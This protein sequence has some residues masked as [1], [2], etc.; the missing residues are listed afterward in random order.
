ML[1][2]NASAYDAS[3]PS[4]EHGIVRSDLQR[5]LLL[6]PAHLS[7]VAWLYHV[8]GFDQSEVAACMGVSRRTVCNYLADFA[9]RARSLDARGDGT[10]RP[11]LRDVANGR[12][13]TRAGPRLID[14]LASRPLVWL[15]GD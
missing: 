11:R 12:P 10:T 9:E 1:V 2:G 8:D 4:S 3:D 6:V 15:Y 7:T 5:T 14:R 13:G